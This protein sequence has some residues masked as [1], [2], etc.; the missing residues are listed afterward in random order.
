[1]TSK[2]IQLYRKE[3][4]TRVKAYRVRFYS[5]GCYT[6]IGTDN[7]EHEVGEWEKKPYILENG[8]V[9]RDK[10]DGYYVGSAF[11][12][13]KYEKFTLTE[14]AVAVCNQYERHLRYEN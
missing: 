1:M 3:N 7:V 5:S 13:P 14:L 8:R 11:G 10:K 6:I 9:S 12:T 4:G 2:T